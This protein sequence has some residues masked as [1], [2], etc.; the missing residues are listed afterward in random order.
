MILCHRWYRCCHKANRTSEYY[1]IYVLVAKMVLGIFSNNVRLCTL[2][3][4]QMEHH[5]LCTSWT[6]SGWFEGALCSIKTVEIRQGKMCLMQKIIL[7]FGRLSISRLQNWIDIQSW[8]AGSFSE[9]CEYWKGNFIRDKS[10][11]DTCPTVIK[12]HLKTIRH[13]IHAYIKLGSFYLTNLIS[14]R[15]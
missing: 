14:A 9:H 5:N 7:D 2:I 10:V 15:C 13:L 4:G 8:L 6:W 12:H 3:Y 1:S 11:R